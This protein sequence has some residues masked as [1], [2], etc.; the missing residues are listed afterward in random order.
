LEININNIKN[1]TEDHDTLKSPYGK[2]LF[3]KINQKIRNPELYQQVGPM[4]KKVC[5]N[6]I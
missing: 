2:S 4:T 6:V 1:K 3:E 5:K